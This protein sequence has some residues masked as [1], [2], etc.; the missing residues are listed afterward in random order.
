M[1]TIIIICLLLIGIVYLLSQRTTV[2]V[3][4]HHIALHTHNGRYQPNLEP[5]RYRFW[6]SGHTF[7]HIDT[8]MQQF[9]LQTQE[10]NTAEGFSIKLTVAGFYCVTD[11]LKATSTSDDYYTTAYTLVQIALRDLVSGTE[12]EN[13]LTSVRDLGPILLNKVSQ[14]TEPL[15]LKFTELVVRD[16][17]LPAEIK[18]TLSEA[19]R[20][21]KHSI[22]ELEAA[23]GKATATRTLAN[24]AKLYESNPSLLKVRYLEAIET[25]AGGVGHTFYIGMSK[26]EAF[27]FAE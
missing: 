25:A 23:R 12:A 14:K 20:A 1:E 22:A 24:A 10:L 2:R 17:I 27:S 16:L 11:P 15:G 19:W 21:K 6:G 13:L 26:E 4:Q 9:T 5:G 7:Q 18:N 3:H 8:R